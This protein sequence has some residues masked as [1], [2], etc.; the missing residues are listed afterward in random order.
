MNMDKATPLQQAIF[1]P[2]FDKYPTELDCPIKGHD[3]TV[4]IVQKHINMSKVPA[5][6]YQCPT[7]R[8]RWFIVT[9][10][11]SLEGLR[12]QTKPRWGWK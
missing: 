11:A 3:H 2:L 1:G 6:T 7:G 12:F 9:P 10:V 5:V 8:Y 4:G